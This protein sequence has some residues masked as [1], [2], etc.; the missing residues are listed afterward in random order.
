MIEEFETIEWARLDT[1]RQAKC[2]ASFSCT[3]PE[4]RDLRPQEVEAEKIIRRCA[5][6]LPQSAFV[7]VGYCNAELVAAAVLEVMLRT[8]VLEVFVQSVGVAPAYRRRGG[9]MADRL[10]EEL[11]GRVRDEANAQGCAQAQVWGKIHVDNIGSLGLADRLDGVAPLRG[12][13]AEGY[14]PFGVRLLA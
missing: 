5:T 9:R 1:K 6:T 2:L 11:Y 3:M 10:I 7:V 4:T 14:Q 12:P 8:E 13:S